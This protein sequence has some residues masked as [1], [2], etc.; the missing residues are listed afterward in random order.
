M[1]VKDS[2]KPEHPGEYIKKQLPEDLTVKDAAKIL[3]VGRPALS[4]LLNGNAALSAEMALRIEKAFGLNKEELIKLQS[5]YDKYDMH[6]R[7][8]EIAVRT[9]APS[10]LDI[11]ARQ[12]EAWADEQIEARSL[13]PAFIRRL[14][15]TTGNN[16]SKTDFPA[17]DNSQKHGWDGYIESDSTTPWIPLGKSGWEFG[18]N[19]NIDTKASKD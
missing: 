7:E 14:V 12:I 11:H 6:E 10:F 17:Y 5:E 16:L 4:N 1:L 2:K 8:K 15:N 3:G 9:Y 18:V 19:K 13:L